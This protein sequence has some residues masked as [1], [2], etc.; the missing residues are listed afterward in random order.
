MQQVIIGRKAEQAEL[1]RCM[2]SLRS[3]FVIVYGRRRV[4][5]TFLVE[6]Y[7]NGLFDFTFVG[8][9]RLA[10]AKQLRAFAKSLK[11]A[12]KLSTKVSHTDKLAVLEALK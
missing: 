4:G 7:F 12:A 6:N 8:G 1:D 11:K 5:K 9:H 2:H 10:K 3:E